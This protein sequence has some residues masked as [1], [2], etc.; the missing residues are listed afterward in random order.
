MKN[1]KELDNWDLVIFLIALFVLWFPTPHMLPQENNES[2]E[3][4]K[5]DE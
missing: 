5:D 1:N 3:V 2:S 4:K